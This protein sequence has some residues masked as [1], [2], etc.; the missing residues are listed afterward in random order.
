MRKV[1][2]AVMAL[3]LFA[4]PAAFAQQQFKMRASVDTSPS[5]ARTLVVAEYLKALQ[6]RSGGRIQTELFS[7]GQLFRDRD[8]VKA[9]RQGGIEMAVPGQLGADRLRAGR[10]RVPAAELLRPAAPVVYAAVDGGIGQ[11]IDDELEDKLDVKLLGPWLPLGYNNTYSTSKPIRSFADMAGMKIRNSGGAGQA[12]RAKFFERAAEHDGLAG[13]AARLVAGHVRRAQLDRRKPGQRQAVGF[14]GEVRVRGPR[15]HR[16]LHPDDQRQLLQEAAAGPAGAG[17][18]RL[19]ENIAAYRTS[20]EAA[21]AQ[22]RKT[23]EANGIVFCAPR[24]GELADD[25]RHDDAA[26]G[27]HGQGAAHQ[28]RAAEAAVHGETTL[29][30]S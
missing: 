29:S 6:E 26:A 13:C 16:L 2:A 25:P 28:P 24:R 27:R 11:I 8:V 15:V 12:I 7:S 4:A 20:M 5:H 22:A 21:Q 17:R 19:E 18:R 9:L 3:A 1:F 14:R 30:G 23:L 10:G